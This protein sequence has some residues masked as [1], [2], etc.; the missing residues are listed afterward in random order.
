MQSR[1]LL[2][3]CPHHLINTNKA[4]IRPITHVGGSRDLQWPLSPSITQV[5]FAVELIVQ[6]RTLNNKLLLTKFNN[7]DKMKC[8]WKFEKSV[9]NVCG[10][11]LECKLAQLLGESQSGLCN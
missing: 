5:N 10:S 9:L 3:F 4:K 6:I 1:F 11:K 7:T 2:W 8:S